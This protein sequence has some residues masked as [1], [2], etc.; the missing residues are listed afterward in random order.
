M[1]KNSYG[2][3]TTS[4]LDE[5]SIEE[6]K[7]LYSNHI[8]SK[9]TNLLEKFISSRKNISHAE[10]A[11]IYTNENTKIL[12]CTGGYGVLNHGHNHPKI[13]EIRKKVQNLK[14]ME[15][16]KNFFSP[17]V[18]ILSHNMSKILS[19]KLEYSFFPNSGSESIDIAVRLCLLRSQS[20][21]LNKNLFLVSDRAFHG[22]S[23]IAQSLSFSNENS[24]KL[25]S[26][27]NFE[28]YQFNNPASLDK[29]MHRD[30]ICGILIEPFSASTM[31]ETSNKMLKSL[32]LLS[33]KT[34]SV[35]IYDEVYSGWFKTGKIFNFMRKENIQWPDIL[36]YGKTLGGGK[37]SISGISYS[38]KKFSK[39]LETNKH[40]NFL[41]S[42][43]YGFYEESVTAI[44]AINILLDENA[45]KVASNI[46]ERM[47]KINNCLEEKDSKYYLQGSGMLW[48]LFFEKNFSAQLLNKLKDLVPRMILE[49]KNFVNKAYA[50]SIISYLYREHE[51]LAGLSFGFNTHVILSFG[52]KHSE[53]EFKKIENAIIELSKI[54]IIKLILDFIGE[55]IL[56]K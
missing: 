36:C 33:K 9:K 37:S 5:I 55:N 47:I 56:T 53:Y 17:A 34:N 6:C 31:S 43:Y 7:K 51:I 54:N 13:L 10:G 28:K 50:A 30:D 11:Y 29:F 1:K 15:V 25:P 48:G 12:D 18:A 42:T 16:N 52:I 24:A 14:K 39:I 44:E 27:L 4:S 38:G 49:D 22:K 20:M 35:L 40:A 2:L 41:S 19:D 45:E 26:L 8:N 32:R 21:N 3:F 23:T 46:N